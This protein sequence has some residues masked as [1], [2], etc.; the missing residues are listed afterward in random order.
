VPDGVKIIGRNPFHQSKISTLT[1]PDS[2]VDIEGSYV[3]RGMANLQ[4]IYGKYASEDNRCLIINGEVAAFAPYNIFQYSIPYGATSIRDWAFSNSPLSEVE[5]PETINY[6]GEYA[7]FRNLSLRSITI[8]D[9]VSVI[10]NSA[11]SNCTSLKEVIFSNNLTTINSHTF[12]HSPLSY[13]LY[14]PEALETIGLHAFWVTDVAVVHIPQNVKEINVTALL[15][16]QYLFEVHCA[17]A[18]PPTITGSIVGSTASYN[19]FD[20]S[21]VPVN[22]YVPAGSVEAYKNADE[23]KEHAS[24]IFAEPEAEDELE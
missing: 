8:P 17:A 7:F 22:I 19:L 20:G 5:L 24:R 14:L 6:I 10:R 2:F 13:H 23:W 9:G 4:G 18:V 16:C 11:F 3:L 15:D 1:L 12:S 21:E